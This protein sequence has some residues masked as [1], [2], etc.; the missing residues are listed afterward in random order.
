M[1]RP[2]AKDSMST[3]VSVRLDPKDYDIFKKLAHT[4]YSQMATIARELIVDWI[5]KNKK[6]LK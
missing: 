3:Q 5:E 1:G 2:R 6:K 4:E